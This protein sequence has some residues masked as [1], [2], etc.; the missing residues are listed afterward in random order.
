MPDTADTAVKKPSGRMEA[1]M[2]TARGAAN[3]ALHETRK[4]AQ[5]VGKAAE[6]NPLAVVAGGIAIGLAAGVLLPRTKRETALLG[7][8]GKRINSAAAGAA[9][10]AKDAAKAELGAF[11]LS[12]Q[13]ARA[14]VSKLLDQVGAAMSAGGE[15]ALAAREEAPAPKPVKRTR[16]KA[17]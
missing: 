15:A 14:Q 11:P 2:T 10:A 7:P 12:K 1:A 9:E 16:R 6:A 17:D 3:D 8:V 4:A 5:R 13:A